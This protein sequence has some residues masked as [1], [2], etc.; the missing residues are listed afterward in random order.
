MYHISKTIVKPSNQHYMDVHVINKA[1]NTIIIV[2]T[3]ISFLNDPV[4]KID[5]LLE[6]L[7][8]ISLFLVISYFKHSSIKE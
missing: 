5:L 4:Q 3:I 7:Q 8:Q 1:R 6:T 2:E